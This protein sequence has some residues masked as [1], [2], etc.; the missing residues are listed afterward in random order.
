[1]RSS[2][3]NFDG[4]SAIWTDEFE[5]K[6][7]LISDYP[8]NC[9]FYDYYFNLE[10]SQWNKFSLELEISDATLAYNS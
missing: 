9:S 1:M 10:S 3:Q 2:M 6:P 7:M 4:Y 8:D 5:E